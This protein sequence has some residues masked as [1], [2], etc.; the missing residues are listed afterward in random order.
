M[1]RNIRAFYFT[2]NMIM[3][4][5]EISRDDKE[6]KIKNAMQIIL[7][8]DG[9]GGVTV[10]IN[11]PFIPFVNDIKKQPNPI[12]VQRTALSTDFALDAKQDAQMFEIYDQT[13][14]NILRP[15]AAQTM[16]I[17]R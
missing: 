14:G 16:S 7:G 4:A 10:G 5:E 1:S 11:A 15:T 12:T 17:I 8:P 6:V 9:K 13:F 3:V 2:N